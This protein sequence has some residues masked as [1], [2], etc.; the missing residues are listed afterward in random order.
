MWLTAAPMIGLG[1]TGPYIFSYLSW[2]LGAQSRCC[3][4]LLRCQSQRAVGAFPRISWQAGTRL[5]GLQRAF[6]FLDLSSKYGM[7]G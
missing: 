3:R 4:W 2:R 1:I 7:D 5:K 6:D